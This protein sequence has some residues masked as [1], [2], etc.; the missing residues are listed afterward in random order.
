MEGWW[1]DER[2]D[3]QDQ[4]VELLQSQWPIH[5]ATRRRR[6]EDGDQRRLL[7]VVTCPAS[8]LPQVIGH[9]LVRWA[10]PAIC[11]IVSVVVHLDWRRQHVGRTLMDELEQRLLVDQ[12]SIMLY[13]WTL[14][15]G[16][17]RGMIDFRTLVWW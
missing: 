2:P 14:D 5:E 16:K 8:Q 7:L 15:Q 12:D 17:H 10:T 4:V 1:L 9:A 11:I 13:L 3:L 6:L